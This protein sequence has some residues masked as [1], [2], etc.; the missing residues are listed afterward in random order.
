MFANDREWVTQL[1][2]ALATAYAA[3]RTVQEK[4]D[5]QSLARR[6]S[7][8]EA[9]P[10]Y[11]KG[12]LVY[13]WERRKEKTGL[14]Q[15]VPSK[16]LSPW[17]GPHKVLKPVHHNCIVIDHTTK[18]GRRSEVTANV[19]RIA[20]C[21]RWS[22]DITSTVCRK[23][24]LEQKDSL[25]TRG[26]PA[27]GEFIAFSYDTAEQSGKDIGPFGIG[28]FEGLAP[29][30]NGIGPWYKFKWYGNYLDKPEGV[31]RPGWLRPNGTS[32]YKDNAEHSAHQGMSNE[33]TTTWITRKDLLCFGFGLLKSGRLPR[34]VLRFLSDHGAVSWH[35]PVE[36]QS[37]SLGNQGEAE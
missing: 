3:A 18:D 5:A 28:R 8:A 36:P 32:Y 11:E 33:H 24:E 37:S 15:T 29:A 31:M 21:R 30:E 34:H 22:E 4:A 25:R 27:P 23:E 9:P 13:Y 16:L 6:R 7:S 26:E 19:N 35:L 17:T 10:T 20:R 12:D 1:S 2:G 14:G